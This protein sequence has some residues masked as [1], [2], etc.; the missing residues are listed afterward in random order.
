VET[1]ET[2]GYVEARIQ[3]LKHRDPKVRKAA[4]SALSSVGSVSAFRGIVLAARDPDPDVRVAVT[5]ALER[6]SGPG[7]AALLKEL[8]SD[9]SPKV[10]KYVLWALERVRA[11]TL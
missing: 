6:L 11:K 9:P 4:A 5:R 7:G 2:Q 3:D 10:R 8:E 1:L